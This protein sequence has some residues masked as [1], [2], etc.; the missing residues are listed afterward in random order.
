VIT[1][2]GTTGNVYLGE[3]AMIEADFSAELDTLLSWADEMAK[4]KVMA[5]ADTPHDAE[6]ALRFGAMGIGLCRTERMFN[7]TERLP[8]VVEM[9]VADT[10]GDRQVALNKLLP[11]QRSRLCRHLQGDGAAPG[12]HPPARPADP[13]IPAQRRSTG[14]RTRPTETPARHL[15]RH[16]GAVRRGGLHVPHP[17]HTSAGRG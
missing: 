16:A 14:G 17:R 12:H 13:R 10:T 1:L 7:A 11:I 6:R 8:I 5:N 4:L 15:A 3:V 9:I 2:D